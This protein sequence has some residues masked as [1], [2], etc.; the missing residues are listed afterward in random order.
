MRCMSTGWQHIWSDCDVPKT[1]RIYTKCVSA[2][3]NITI[4]IGLH[5]S[6]HR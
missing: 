5:D 3:L 6:V 1:A 2:G 4:A